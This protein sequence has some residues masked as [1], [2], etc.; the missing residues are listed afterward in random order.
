MVSRQLPHLTL[1][2]YMEGSSLHPSSLSGSRQW[3][4]PATLVL[5]KRQPLSS[6]QGPGSWINLDVEAK[7][8]IK[9][10]CLAR[11]MTTHSFSVG[12]QQCRGP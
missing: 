5:G 9:M 4:E 3:P 11:Y 6:F 12:L 1:D 2:K 8:A 10:P 7:A